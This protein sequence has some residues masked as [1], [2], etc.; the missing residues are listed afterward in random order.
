MVAA[1]EAAGVRFMVHE[2]FRWQTPM[3]ALKAA[4]AEIGKLFFARI[5]WRSAEDVYKNQPYLATDSRFIV[6]D[7]GVHL[8]DLARFYLGE[9]EALHC[10][11]QR[12]NPRI[13]AEDV[14]T[15][16]LRMAGGAACVRFPGAGSRTSYQAT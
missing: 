2:N 10:L 9:A 11:T 16:L 4:A 14:A 12:V 7:L 8:L 5:T 6:Y 3:R 1:C 15:I 13:R